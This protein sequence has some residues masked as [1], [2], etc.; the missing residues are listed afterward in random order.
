MYRISENR[1][2]A[3]ARVLNLDHRKNNTRATLSQIN[4]MFKK[5][6][7]IR[8]SHTNITARVSQSVK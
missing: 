5:S 2:R 6:T 8:I 1:A 7:Q 3:G 4:H